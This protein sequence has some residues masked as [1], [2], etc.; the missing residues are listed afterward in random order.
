MKKHVIIALSF[1]ALVA[2]SFA[3]QPAQPDN[4]ATAKEKYL[5]IKLGLS[6]K[7]YEGGEK[8]SKYAFEEKIKTNPEARKFYK[9]G[10]NLDIAGKVIGIPGGLI[11][12]YQIGRHIEYSIDKYYRK[13]YFPEYKGF[14]V[15][16]TLISCCALVTGMG[17][18]YTSKTQ[19][20]NAV[21]AYNKSVDP[22]IGYRLGVTPNGFGLA[23]QF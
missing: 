4:V 15:N 16:T 23:L 9:S 21:R 5:A 7:Y 19:K 13:K 8:I 1:L 3:Q 22:G 2:Q 11:L 18:A 10:K 6:K 12:G 20:R 17:L 14:N